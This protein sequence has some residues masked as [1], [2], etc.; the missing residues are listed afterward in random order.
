MPLQ[1]IFGAK[2]WAVKSKDKVIWKRWVLKEKRVLEII[3][4][5]SRWSKIIYPVCGCK[6]S[7]ADRFSIMSLD[8]RQPEQQSLDFENIPVPSMLMWELEQILRW[9]L[10]KLMMNEIVPSLSPCLPFLELLQQNRFIFRTSLCDSLWTVLVS[11]FH[12]TLF[13][14]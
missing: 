3:V 7:I 13:E 4:G 9:R 10:M 14:H 6:D 5:I 2:V 12:C 1:W 8:V 11:S